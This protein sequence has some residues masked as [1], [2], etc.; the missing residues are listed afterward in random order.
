MGDTNRKYKKAK[1]SRMSVG[2]L[3]GGRGGGGMGGELNSQ[4]NTRG[5]KDSGSSQG[6]CR[7]SKELRVGG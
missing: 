4:K 3:Q 1:S 2:K 7:K 6:V 5:G